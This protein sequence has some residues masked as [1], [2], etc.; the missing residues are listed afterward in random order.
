MAPDH[1]TIA[2]QLPPE[3][4]VE[5]SPR[6]ARSAERLPVLKALARTPRAKRYAIRTEQTSVDWCHRFLSFAGRG[7]EEDL[8]PR[9]VEHCLAHLA[10]DR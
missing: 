1:P 2:R 10:A 9:D 8:E 6:F 3:Q 7:A 4:A 5:S